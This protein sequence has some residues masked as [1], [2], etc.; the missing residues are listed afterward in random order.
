LR[1]YFKSDPIVG[2]SNNIYIDQINLTGSVVTG[3]TEIEKSMDLVIYPNPTASTS[4]IDFT[5]TQN[6]SVKINI[7]DVMGRLLEEA[8]KT[9]DNDGHVSYIINQNNNLAAGVYFVNIDIDN[10]RITKKVIIE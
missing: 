7:V 10:Q 8:S 5:I 1:F 4:T 6:K 3:I 9:A 2:R